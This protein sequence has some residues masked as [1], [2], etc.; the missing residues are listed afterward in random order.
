MKPVKTPK[1]T[2]YLSEQ[3]WTDLKI[4]CVLTHSTMSHLIRCAIKD[5]LRKIKNVQKLNND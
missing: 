4:V 1:V 5:K 3:E 2:F